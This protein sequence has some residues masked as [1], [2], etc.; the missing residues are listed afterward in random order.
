MKKDDIIIKTREVIFINSELVINKSKK[1][2]NLLLKKI[3]YILK[4][5]LG[6]LVFVSFYVQTFFFMNVLNSSGASKF[7]ISMNDFIYGKKYLYAFFAL[8][9]IS[10]T[11]LFSDRVRS[12]LLVIL[13][14]LYSV[15]LVGDLWYYRGFQSFLSLHNLGETQN[16]HNNMH[17][18]ALAMTRRVDMYFVV[19]NIIIILFAILIRKKYRSKKNE[20][21]VFSVLFVVSIVMLSYFNSIGKYTFNSQFVPLATMRNITPIGYHFYDTGMYIKD[22]MPHR[23]SAKDK[24]EVADWINFKNENLPANEYTGMFKGKNLIFIQVESLEN[25]VI[26]QSYNGQVLTPNLNAMLKNSLYFPNFYEQVNTGNSA[27]ADLMVN[28]SVLPIRRGSTF[29]RFPKNQYN[30]LSEML[31]EDNYYTRSLHAADGNIWNI[32]KA[33]KK[34]DFDECMD[35][36]DFNSGPVVNM[37]VTDESFY[38]QVATLTDKDKS[39]FYYYTVSVSSHVPFKLPDDMKSLKLPEKFDETSMGNYMQAINYADIQIGNFLKILDQK[40][41]LNNSLVVVMGDHTGI[42]KYYNDRVKAMSNQE[43]WWDNDTKVPFIIYDK[44]LQGKEIKTIGA[45]I[46]VLP[47]VASL[48]GI[49]ENKYKNTTM[50]RNLLNTNKSYAILNDGTIKGAD[51]LSKEELDHVKKSFDIADIILQTNYFNEVK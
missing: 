37:G 8:V 34:F 11:Y 42:H 43:A 10:F 24:K 5:S 1:V 18:T 51:T 49:D 21:G 15:L 35:I 27:D 13:N 39:P 2:A 48:M 3:L 9:I 26:N 36:K 17:G 23:L 12:K 28:A 50:G 46:D 6:I 4:D 38:K 14:L 41:V 33:F 19:D 40:G 31:K 44:S 20:R 22:N 7:K 32:T 47:T 29:F 30:T 25:F 45:E 16:L